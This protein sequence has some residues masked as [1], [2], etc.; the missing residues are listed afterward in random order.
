[1]PSKTKKISSEKGAVEAKKKK[2]KKTKPESVSDARE[3]HDPEKDRPKG[4]KENSSD[5]DEEPAIEN[6]EDTSS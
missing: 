3:A 4:H 6:N 2:N 1:M 5:H